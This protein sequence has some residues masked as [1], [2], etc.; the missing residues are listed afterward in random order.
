MP[1]AQDPVVIAGGGVAGLE[2]ALALRELLGVRAPLVLVTPAP[3]FHY[4]A[5]GVG[6]AFGLGH[7]HRHPIG[8][9]ARDLGMEVVQDTVAAVDPAAGQ[10]RLAS[11]A[12]L[13]YGRLVLAVGAPSRAPFPHG[14]L[15]D[16]VANATGFEEVLADLQ[17]GLVTHVALAIGP[18]VTWPLPA[19]ELALMTAAWGAAARPEGVDVSVLSRES[20]PLDLFGSAASRAV[21]GVLDR[22]G[23]AFAGGDDLV[24]ESDETVR[25]GDRQIRAERIVVLPELTGP[26]VPGLPGD[27]AGFVPVDPWGRVPGVERVYAVGDAAAHPIKQG[28]L[29]AQQATA[30]AQAIAFDSGARTRATVPRPVLRGLLRT[31]EGPL[32]LRATLEDPEATSTASGDPLWWPPSKLAAPRLTSYLRR[33]EQA[34]AEGRVL[35]LVALS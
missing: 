32:Y 35:P 6:E 17:A 13:P 30:A 26:R 22:A 5:L 18:G 31:V 34:R 7:P 3:T 25:M 2:A 29:A 15:F 12:G 10:L 27:A 1:F 20:A 28:G 9:I 4:R 23:V 33:I 11:G 8:P 16:P 24:V 14:V 19:Y 21:A